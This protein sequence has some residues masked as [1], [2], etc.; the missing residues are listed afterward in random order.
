MSATAERVADAEWWRRLADRYE[1]G[2]WQFT[3]LC[4]QVSG[5]RW[6]TIRARRFQQ[7]QALHPKG[8][9]VAAAELLRLNQYDGYW[10]TREQP[11]FSSER[12]TASPVALEA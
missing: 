10:W 1:K 3:G 5:E 7:I 12:A 2:F 11:D 8:P 4:A 9:H 6:P